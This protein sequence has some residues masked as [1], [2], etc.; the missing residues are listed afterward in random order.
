VYPGGGGALKGP[1][2]P[3]AAWRPLAAQ[4]PIAAAQRQRI[5]RRPAGAAFSRNSIAQ[6]FLPRKTIDFRAYLDRG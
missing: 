4:F 3:R 2:A 6:S 5:D 1:G